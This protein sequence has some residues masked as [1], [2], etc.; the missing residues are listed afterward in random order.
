VACILVALEP[1]E[2]GDD[3]LSVLLPQGH[4]VYIHNSKEGIFKTGYS[5]VP[6]LL[7][8][9]YDSPEYSG[10]SGLEEIRQDP[11]LRPARIVLFS[12]ESGLD[13]VKATMRFGVVG[14]LPKPISQE[15]IRESLEQIISSSTGGGKRREF[16]RVKP[17]IGENVD[18]ELFLDDV[19]AGIGGTVMD[20]SIGGVACRL[21]NP[22]RAGEIVMG[23]TYA[24]MDITLSRDARIQ[25]EVTAVIARG[26][27][28]A[29]RISQMGDDSLRLLCRY[30]YKRLVEGED[31]GDPD[32]AGRLMQI[33]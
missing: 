23:Q 9:D 2:P 6:D 4:E 33:V 19:S 14:Y 21:R 26:D 17:A 11:K 20:I 18:F 27:T 10:L 12:T 13:F 5:R 8:I 31:T 30:I 25:V 32:Q 28:V 29:F 15:E 1:G 3:F 24:R 7:I 16:V 22:K